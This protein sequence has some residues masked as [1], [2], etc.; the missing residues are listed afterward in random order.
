MTKTCM[1]SLEQRDFQDLRRKP[2]W[3]PVSS[4]SSH[5]SRIAPSTPTASRCGEYN[6]LTARAVAVSPRIFRKNEIFDISNADK[7][8]IRLAFE[9][10][11]TR[12]VGRLCYRDMKGAMRALECDV[13]KA[14]VLK[15]MKQFSKD[16]NNEIDHEEFMQ[17]IMRKYKEKDP[18]A[19]IGK[20]WTVYDEEGR[21]KISIKNVRK[22]ARDL[23]E[24]F[25]DEQLEAMITIFDRDGDGE[26]MVS[27]F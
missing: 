19:T 16:D 25:T 20:M 9:L 17:I 15:L 1:E 4:S 24:P 22:V 2:S 21:G 11:D 5:L 27:A 3:N 26:G 12:K 14:E 8:E 6:T 18:E 10:F 7:F 23:G 13:K